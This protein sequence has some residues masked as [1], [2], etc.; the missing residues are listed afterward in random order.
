MFSPT[1]IPVNENAINVAM[2]IL[3]Q[4]SLSD[5]DFIRLFIL[6]RGQ[7]ELEDEED[8]QLNITQLRRAY[9]QGN[10]ILKRAIAQEQKKYSLLLIDCEEESDCTSEKGSSNDLLD[11]LLSDSES[12]CVVATSKRV[13]VDQADTYSLQKQ[14]SKTPDRIKTQET[15]Q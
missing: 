11:G 4:P 1:T 6:L 2:N 12:M 7:S 5:S 15:Q 14:E 3:R 8:I 13:R 10:R 9:R